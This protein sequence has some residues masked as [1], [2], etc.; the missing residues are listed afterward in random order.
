MTKIAREKDL[1]HTVPAL[2]ARAKAVMVFPMLLK[3]AFLVG[4]EGGTGV[5]LSRDEA[6]NWSSPA[7]YTLGALSF[8][9][10]IG[11]QASE[12]MLIIMTDRGLKSII[13]DQ[14]KLGGDLSVAVGPVGV[15]TAA[16]TTTAFSADVYSYSVNQGLYLGGSLEG[17]VIARRIPLTAITNDLT[18]ASLFAQEAGITTIVI[19]GTVRPGSTTLIGSPGTNFLQEIHADLA[20]IGTHSICDLKLS[21]TSIEA[22]HM[23]RA[24]IDAASRVIALADSSKFQEPSFSLICTVDAVDEIITDSKLPAD[25]AESIKSAGTTLTMVPV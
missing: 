16:A 22:S 4:G 9:L 24:I 3:G 15:G 20:F 23:K 14:V 21:E 17:A 2:L 11:G 1:R 6:G 10:Q 25:I 13:D 7:F 12:A 5:L 19:G 8:G 18:T